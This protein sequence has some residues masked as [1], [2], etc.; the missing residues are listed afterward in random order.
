MS[1]G[2]FPDLPIALL[3][4]PRMSP[5][6]GARNCCISFA[7]LDTCINARLSRGSSA[8]LKTIGSFDA[9]LDPLTK[10][11]ALRC[12]DRN[13]FSSNVAGAFFRSSCT[14]VHGTWLGL[15][16]GSEGISSPL[17]LSITEK[18]TRANRH[19]DVQVT[20]HSP[21]APNKVDELC[22]LV[23]ENSSSNLSAGK[24]IQTWSE[25]YRVAPFFRRPPPPK[26]HH[27]CR[28]SRTEPRRAKS[29]HTYMAACR[30]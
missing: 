6:P 29:W 20:C 5:S 21:S 16:A 26:G 22:G 3:P 14:N 23:G 7:D 15:N 24:S 27:T 13:V 10:S 12:V 30:A 1:Y 25:F 19:L 9:R 28:P 8:K 11:H 18:I 4:I 2:H 17:L